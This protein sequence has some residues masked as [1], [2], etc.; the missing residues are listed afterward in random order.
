MKPD[1]KLEDLQR[2]LDKQNEELAEAMRQ[3]EE[4]SNDVNVEVPQSF[5]H[6]LEEAC[7]PRTFGNIVPLSFMLRG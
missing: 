2:E 7:T 6:D 4:L 5:F 3:L 1:T